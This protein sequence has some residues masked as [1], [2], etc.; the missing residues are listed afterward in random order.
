MSERRVSGVRLGGLQQQAAVRGRCLLGGLLLTLGSAGGCEIDC[1]E[2]YCDFVRAAAGGI[3]AWEYQCCLEPQGPACEDRAIRYQTLA[4]GAPS[5]RMACEERNWDRVGE[6]WEEV[7]RVLPAVR[8]PA[9]GQPP[10]QPRGRGGR[11]DG[12]GLRRLRG[13]AEGQGGQ[14]ARGRGPAPAGRLRR[15]ARPPAAPDVSTP[16]GRALVGAAG[17]GR[18]PR[19][20]R[21][22]YDTHRLNALR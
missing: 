5:M 18:H 9:P 20:P 6:I 21:Y 7:R 8:R 1:D 12:R 19:Y 4:F 3:Y 2:R 14:G 16:R 17:L 22:T 15:G 10:R 11:G 13:P